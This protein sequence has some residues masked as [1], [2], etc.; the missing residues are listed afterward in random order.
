MTVAS[1]RV[2]A[3][4]ARL[5]PYL[6]M[7]YGVATAVVAGLLLAGTGTELWTQGLDG[8]NLL[9][10]LAFYLFL[11]VGLMY[12]QVALVATLQSYMAGD[13]LTFSQGFSVASTRLGPLVRWAVVAASVGW[14][15][16]YLEWAARRRTGYA[17]SVAS[18][19]TSSMFGSA[20]S[21]ATFF[22]VPIIAAEGHNARDALRRSSLVVRR[23]WGETIVSS[24]GIALFMTVVALALAGV[25]FIAG[26]V[27]LATDGTIGGVLGSVFL[28]IAGFVLLFVRITAGMLSVIYTGVLYRHATGGG[29]PLFPQEMVDEAFQSANAGA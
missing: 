1:F 19:I 2:L 5:L 6:Y 29:A 28:I 8:T 23:R 9:M 16:R 12:L 13:G 14:V 21:I 10:I 26:L 3:L 25:P 15:L 11:S 24:T 18:R 7:A 22:T 4:D 17:G 20:W 27:L